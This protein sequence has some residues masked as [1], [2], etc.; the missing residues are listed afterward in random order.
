[1][2]PA[3]AELTKYAANAMLA[4][5]HLVHERDREP[6]R[7][8][9]RR[10]AAGAPAAWARTAR[11]GPSFLFP[12]VG[13]GGSC[14]PKDVKALVRDGRRTRA[15][16][17]QVVEA[18]DRANEA[19][20]TLLR[21][22][23][24]GA[25]G[26]RSRAR[27]SR[28]GASPSSRAPT[29][30]ARRRRWP[31]SRRCCEGGAAV[32]AYDPKAMRGGA[33]RCWATASRSARAA[34]RRWRARTP[35][36]GHGVERVPRA[37]LRAHQVAHA[38]ARRSSTAATSTTRRRCASWASTT[39]GSA[40]GEGR[41]SPGGAGYIGSHAV[42]ELRDAGPRGDRARRPLAGPPRGGARR[43]CR[44]SR[45][46]SATRPRSARAL[47][48]RRGR[49]P[50]RR[51]AQRRRVGRAIPAAY[52][53][54]E[55]G[56]G[57]GAAGRHGAA[58][59]ARGSSS[60]PPAPPTACPCACPID[61]DAPAGPDQPLR[62]HQA[63]LRA[64][65]ARPRRA[66]AAL[67]AVAL[68]YFNAAGLPSRRHAW[69]RTT[70]PRSTSSRSRSTPRSGR[71]PALTDPTATT[72]TRPTAPASAT[73]STCRTWRART[74][75]PWRRSD[76]ARAVR[77]PST[78]APGPGTRCSEV[79]EAVERVA[80]RAGAR[81]AWARGARA[82]RRAGGRG[83]QGPRAAGLPADMRASRRSWRPP[84]AGAAPGGYDGLTTTDRRA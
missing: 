75:W 22:A 14:F 35:W 79:V 11:I 50:L 40:A 26:R 43:T 18:V 82:T 57:P 41:W 63:R 20:K 52:Y 72:T 38:P 46:T 55:R 77:R 84:S 33:A 47:D 78:W 17:L 30:C 3:S 25:P 49:H 80:G 62:R 27:W 28:S 19:Q 66:P 36:S 45:A 61:E 15:S 29:T 24:R 51:P 65:P 1:M 44:S 2:D 68:R 12:G 13:Y 39:R 7:P 69:A 42:R 54:I 31:S 32:R 74:C 23:H 16:T 83:R 81:D 73:T 76:A 64:R 21:A 8:G 48:G 10:R 71:R 9:G 4:T 58:R 6:V 53:R 67:R 56:E 37:R 60:A 59:R 70:T 34:T 5:P